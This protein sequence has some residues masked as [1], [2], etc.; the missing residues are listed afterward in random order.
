MEGDQIILQDIF[1]FEQQGLRDGKV[2]GNLRPTGFVPRCLD[3]LAAMN[4]QL[5]TTIFEPGQGLHLENTQ[6]FSQYMK[7]FGR[8]EEEQRFY[9][10]DWST[11]FEPE[12]AEAVAGPAGP[13]TGSLAERLGTGTKRATAEE[14]AF[15]RKVRR[16]PA[17]PM[18]QFKFRVQDRVIG[19]LG[20]RLNKTNPA[21]VRAA[22]E[23][24]L[25]GAL[26]AEGLL[27]AQVDRA[28]LVKDIEAEVHGYGPLQTL[29]DD[30]SI[31]E[32]MANGP[33]H[34]YVER[35]GKV[36]L[37]P[38]RFYDEEH[39]L[40]VIDR[41]LTPLGRR[42]DETSPMADARLPDGSRANIVIPP[43]SL[44]GPTI[45][46]RKFSKK[47][48]TTEDLVSIGSITSDAARFLASCVRGRLNIIV[49]G[50]ASSGKTTLLNIL[51]SYIPSDERIVT[52]ETTAELSLSQ[53]HVVPLE[54]RPPNIE[55]KG[56]VDVRQLVINCLRMRPERIVV[57]EC[58]GGEA[59]DM[60]QAMNTGHDG[61]LTTTHANSPIDVISRMEVMCMMAGM[62]LPSKAIRE[63]IASAVQL[64]VHMNRLRDGT[65]KV[66]QV[67]EIQGMEGEQIILQDIFVFEQMGVREGKVVGQLRP[68]GFVPRCLDTL[69]A[70]NEHVP[71]SIFEPKGGMSTGG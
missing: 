25:A 44:V 35:S 21:E 28:R 11:M 1:V 8:H 53:E 52:V 22:V 51:S 69:A 66:V 23:R 19:E 33:D 41:I 63:Q 65:R 64:I 12:Q 39:M 30:A 7:R 59:I 32:I 61:S 18:V 62:N 6:S 60:L 68:T 27:L 13:T 49:S 67:T 40:R 45:T 47:K 46:I 54:A 71:T 57:G 2:V 31:S 55:G 26:S 58:R 5:P 43:L 15:G 42:V 17:D 9:K 24:C 14:R 36:E 20:P 48:F 29:L 38:I 50:G 3:T 10:V 16:P 34:V 56:E 70:M 4:V 37:S